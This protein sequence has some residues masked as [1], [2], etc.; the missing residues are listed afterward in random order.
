[1]R[2]PL[3]LAETFAQLFRSSAPGRLDRLMRTPLQ[4]PLLEAIF[5]QMP[6]Q[7]DRKQAARTAGSVRWR[8]L[9]PCD[10]EADT[11]D[12]ELSD[13]RCR[14]T[15]G[16]RAPDPQ[17]TITVDGGEFLRIVT[18]SSDPMKAYFKGRIKLGG[19]IMFAA[20]L[21]ALFRIPGSRR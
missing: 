10:G 18:G 1:M 7:L 21:V 14:V 16:E 9:G 12:L 13:G 2:R 19:D 4:R 15:R 3:T 20:K 5:W 8:I 11:Y 17:L 6:R